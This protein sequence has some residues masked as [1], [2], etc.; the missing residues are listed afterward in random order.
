MRRAVEPIERYEFVDYCYDLAPLYAL[1]VSV[2][3]MLGYRPSKLEGDG[4]SRCINHA[5]VFAGQRFMASQ[6]PLHTP[7]AAVDLGK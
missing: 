7:V 4:P 6:W 3:K 1:G 2:A 5:S